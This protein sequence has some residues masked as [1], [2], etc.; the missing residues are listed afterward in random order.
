M[1]PVTHR[2][3]IG[4]AVGRTN[5]YMRTLFNTLI[6][7]E[8]INLTNEQWTVLKIISTTPGI[9]QT[10]I[11]ERSLKDKTNITRILDGLEKKNHIVRDKDEND[12]RAYKI[13]IT[14]EG[15]KIL[16]EV[17]PVL[18]KIERIIY[19][20][21]SKSDIDRVKKLLDSICNNIRPN[22]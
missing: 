10:E 4:Y 12:R 15:K 20:S 8:N 2:D 14:K 11:A 1:K 13:N 21:L 5:W 6:R 16:K 19:D 17:E 3:T 9:S 18:R 22:I 7:E